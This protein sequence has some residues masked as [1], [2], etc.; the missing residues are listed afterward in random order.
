MCAAE[1]KRHNIPPLAMG[2]IARLAFV[3]AKR[4]GIDVD[5]LLKRAG[6]SRKQI[7]DPRIRFEAQTQIKF[8]ELVA[9]ASGDDF[10]GFHLAQGY[11]LREMGFLYYVIASADRFGDALQLFAKYCPVINEGLKLTLRKTK[12]A[13]GIIFEYEGISRPFER[14]Q[15]EF[16][17]TTIMR[18][19]RQVTNR[20][21]TPERVSFSHWRSAAPELS[22]FFGCEITF[23]A[24][25]DEAMFPS[26]IEHT[27]VI[28]CDPY[29]N[30]LLTQYHD[31]VLAHRQAHRS[32]FAV[33]VENAIFMLMPRGKAQMS[34]VAHELGIGPRTLA[35]RLSSEGLT[36]ADML[37][38]LRCDL[39]KR[40]L[41]EEDLPVSKIAWLVGYQDISAFT[42]AFKCWTGKAPA[43]FR[44]GLQQQANATRH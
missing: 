14:H 9:D 12:E 43:E 41:A 20:N 44:K 26:S 2:G 25:I 23:G 31:D 39:A 16:L 29:L 40:H 8:L 13:I 7:V 18:I 5:A 11:D 6:L 15:I 33:N 30:K 32:S 38:H 34:Y 27:T 42:T 37:R 17:V 35:R 4:K 3:H 28:N 10:L 21:L 22:R 1:S 36:F 24:D 19:C